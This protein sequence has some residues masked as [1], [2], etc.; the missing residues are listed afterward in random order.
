[1]K[2]KKQFVFHPKPMYQVPVDAC[3]A[4]ASDGP[5][6]GIEAFSGLYARNEVAFN[7]FDLP[8]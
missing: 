5:H 4:V 2:A 1:M 8:V 3:G 6:M 7:T